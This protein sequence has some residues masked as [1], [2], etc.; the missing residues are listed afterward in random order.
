[1]GVDIY[2]TVEDNLWALVRTIEALRQIERDGSPAMIE[3]A[4]RGFAALPDPMDFEGWWIPLGLTS[5]ATLDEVRSA[6]RALAK[7]YHPDVPVTGDADQFRRIEA[8]YKVA[9]KA[10]TPDGLS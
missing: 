2:T 5:K 3:R 7:R 8:A 9:Q 4:F 1:M 10:L 6:F